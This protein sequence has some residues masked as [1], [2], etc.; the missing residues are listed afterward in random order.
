[1]DAHTL[2]AELNGERRIWRL[3]VIAR[4]DDRTR[5]HAERWLEHQV[6]LEERRQR[7][8]ERQRGVEGRP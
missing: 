1:M 2:T 4:R 3:T 6:R 5:R 8:E 7:I